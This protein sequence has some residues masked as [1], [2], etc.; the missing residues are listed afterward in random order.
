MGEERKL[1]M[2]TENNLLIGRENN[3]ENMG[4]QKLMETRFKKRKCMK[5]TNTTKRSGVISTEKG[6]LIW[7]SDNY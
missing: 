2:D 4:A 5:I 6:M 7:Q 1:K 3:Q